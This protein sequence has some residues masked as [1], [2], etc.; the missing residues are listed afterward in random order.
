MALDVVEPVVGRGFGEDQGRM[1]QRVEADEQ[2]I[3]LRR[4]DEEDLHEES[5]RKS[6]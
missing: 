4:A 3:G 6:S 2:A 1:D 5:L